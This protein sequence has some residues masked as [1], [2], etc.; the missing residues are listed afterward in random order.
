MRLH[1]AGPLAEARVSGEAVS[2]CFSYRPGEVQQ[3]PSQ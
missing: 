2:F 1:E 3:P